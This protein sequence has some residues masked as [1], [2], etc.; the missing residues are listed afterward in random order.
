LALKGHGDHARH[1][2]PGPVSEEFDLRAGDTLYLPRG[3]VHEAISTDETS[4]HVTVG[5]LSW[6]WF[7]FLLEAVERLASS[8]CQVRAALPPAFARSDCDRGA[9]GKAFAE[10][11]APRNG[12][13]CR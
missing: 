12:S 11:A 6:T 13:R 9:F 8:D 10:L 3:L 4:L 1:D 5:I 2:N 7:D